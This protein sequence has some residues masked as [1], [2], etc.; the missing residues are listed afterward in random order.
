MA[1]SPKQDEHVRL[2]TVSEVTIS[3]T[4]LIHTFQKRPV[5][6]NHVLLYIVAGLADFTPN[7]TF[8]HTLVRL[9]TQ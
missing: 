5:I 3:N 1:V 7:L 2:V 9:S 4:G 6:M 8:Y